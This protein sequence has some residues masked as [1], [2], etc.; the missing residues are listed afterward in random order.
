MNKVYINIIKRFL[1]LIFS[2][3]FLILL[4]PIIILVSIAIKIDSPGSVFFRQ[5]RTGVNGR[6]FT[7]LKFRSMAKDNNVLDF[8][9]GDRITKVGNF[10]RKTSLDEIPQL[11]NIIKGDM[12][13]IGPRPWIRECYDYFTPYQKQRNLVRPGIT[14]LAQV[15]GR[16]DLNILKRIDIDIDYV[17]NISLLF[18]LEIIFKTIIVVLDSSD[19]THENYT[20]EDELIDLKNNYYKYLRS[21]NNDN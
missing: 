4:S 18:D 5:I 12:S 15:S 13:F 14:G 21:N 6:D 10:L 3:L 11:I 7:L 9:T 20:V 1:D 17:N 19:N 8:E 2:I 16:K